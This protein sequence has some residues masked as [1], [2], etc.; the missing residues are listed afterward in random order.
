[1]TRKL[2]SFHTFRGI[3]SLPVF[4]LMS[5]RTLLPEIKY[6]I[7]TGTSWVSPQGI[8]SIFARCRARLGAT[9]SFAFKFL[10]LRP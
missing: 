9:F 5:R 3:V 2:I 4:F 6:R 10:D 7:G 8:L 1:M